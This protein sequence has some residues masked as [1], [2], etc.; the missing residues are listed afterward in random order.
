LE[1]DFFQH[2]LVIIEFPN[3]HSAKGFYESVEYQPLLKLRIESGISNSA[4][5]QG[6]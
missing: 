6:T 4:L 1:G 2:R 3:L 5:V